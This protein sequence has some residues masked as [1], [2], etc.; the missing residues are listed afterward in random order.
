[1]INDLK[2]SYY[3]FPSRRYVTYSTDG[4]VAT[5]QPIAAQV[6]RDILNAGGNAVD[7]AV[8]MAAVLTVVEPT[9]NGI[10][11]DAFALVW[12]QGKLYGLNASGPSPGCLTL[13]KLLEKGHKE[14]PSMGVVPVTVPGAPAGWAALSDRF[15]FLRFSKLLD[16]AIKFALEGFN[17]QTLSAKIWK[18]YFNEHKQL[19]Q[20][21][22]LFQPWLQ[23]FTRE[24]KPPQAGQRIEFPDHA[25][26]LKLIA[27]TKARDFYH[28]SIAEKI[29]VYFKAHQGYLTKEDLQAYEPRWVEPVEL[30]YNGYEVSE[31]PPNGH[32]ITV[33]LAL[34]I[35][36][37][38]D[39]Y[40]NAAP[41]LQIH[42]EIEAMKLAFT[43]T[44][45]YVADQETMRVTIEALLSNKYA[46]D[47]AAL[48]SGMALMPEHGDPERGG[49]VYLATADRYGNMVSFIQSNY[50]EFGSGVVIPGTG[51]AMHNRGLNFSFD[52]ESGNVLAGNKWPYHTIIPGFLTRGGKPVGPF[53]VMGGFMQPQGHFQI[54]LNTI[55]HH[56]NPQAAL[57]KPRWQ[58]TGGKTIEL[59]QGFEPA[60]AS[61][62]LERGHDVVIKADTSTFGR[63]QIIWRDLE[64]H[65]CAGCEPR[66]DS[67]IGSL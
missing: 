53:G 32:G 35:L 2:M 36:K 19:L 39:G 50:M 40:Q 58:W 23:T 43:D 63:G 57:D 66:T 3:P 47:R 4:M 15:G 16:P 49:T 12:Q 34:N 46:K 5:S 64:G 22:P 10:G 29:D 13:E 55:D 41:D 65:L 45:K 6:G 18:N 52:R 54:L 27:Q 20:S 42:Y 14:M 59:E 33:L 28:G 44:K 60:I 62:L 31:I 51:I 25:K 7:A 26:T 21:D 37:Q 67:L 24:G 38:L 56:L 8:A 48:I 61:Q 17:V 1:M 9:G 30:E 11:G